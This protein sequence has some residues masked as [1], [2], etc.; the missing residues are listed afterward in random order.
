ML[1]SRFFLFSVLPIILLIILSCV[2]SLAKAQ[3]ENAGEINKAQHRLYPGGRDEQS[4]EIQ[5]ALPQP[6]RSLTTA[7]GAAPGAQAPAASEDEPAA[8]AEPAE[9]D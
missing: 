3:E 6:L 8:P 1:G 7:T 5:A 9:V 4:L 2:F